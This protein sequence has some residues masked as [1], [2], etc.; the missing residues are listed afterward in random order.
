MR[1]EPH[2]GAQLG[3]YTGPVRERY[4]GN[5]EQCAAY[6]P[7]GRKLLAY[8]KTSFNLSGAVVGGQR[9]VL[10]N[11]VRIEARVDGVNHI[12][13]IDTRALSP[14]KLTEIRLFLE[15]GWIPLENLTDEE[16]WLTFSP[17]YYGTHQWAALSQ[18]F[19]TWLDEIILTLNEDEVVTHQRAGV[20]R[21][22]H[23]P[24]LPHY[25]PESHLESIGF[26]S[27]GYYDKDNIL[28]YSHTRHAAAQILS[29]GYATGKLKLYLQSLLGGIKDKNFILDSKDKIDPWSQQVVTVVKAIM[30]DYWAWVNPGIAF[31]W[32]FSRGLYTADNYRYWLISIIG[33][34]VLAQEI[35][36]GFKF[37][38]FRRTMRKVLEDPD[39]LFSE[40]QKIEAYILSGGVEFGPQIVVAEDLLADLVGVPLHEGWKFN[41]KGTDAQIVTKEVNWEVNPANDILTIRSHTFRRYHI[42]LT[43]NETATVNPFTATISRLEEVEA[44]PE[45]KC[46]RPFRQPMSSGHILEWEDWHE[47]L[48]GQ[49][50]GYL[51]GWI[52]YD[53]PLYCWYCLNDQGV[54]TFVTLRDIVKW[55]DEEISPSEV[56]AAYEAFIGP[57][58][59]AYVC[60]GNQ[61]IRVENKIFSNYVNAKRGY[62]FR[63]EE[64]NEEDAPIHEDLLKSPEDYTYAVQLVDGR[65]DTVVYQVSTSR[66]EASFGGY[67][68][69]GFPYGSINCDGEAAA[70]PPEFAGGL[71]VD[72]ISDWGTWEDYKRTIASG[73]I[74]FGYVL[75]FPYNDGASAYIQ[76]NTRFLDGSVHINYGY[77]PLSFSWNG[78]AVFPDHTVTYDYQGRLW[79]LGSHGPA[80]G[81]PDEM[82]PSYPDLRFAIEYPEG[83]TY[84]SYS[85]NWIETS[86]NRKFYYASA[87]NSDL[88]FNETATLTGEK[89]YYNIPF[90]ISDPN[91]RFLYP[92]AGID[93]E[94]CFGKHAWYVEI[95][96]L[97]FWP[98]FDNVV[99]FNESMGGDAF[100]LQQWGPFEDQVHMPLAPIYNTTDDR[101]PVFESTDGL[102]TSAAK[103]QFNSVFTGWA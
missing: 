90:A 44:T 77:S 88:V 47:W 66:A 20:V 72:I 19:P 15:T 31:S 68:D 71:W 1:D 35:K 80:A 40:R 86:D 78:T 41:Y 5:P 65:L 42:H 61:S 29:P 25:P 51:I 67:E 89:W 53:A 103:R 87:H 27:F 62:Y 18:E 64:G 11:G 102:M 95:N 83:Q 30:G 94:E 85:G 14:G 16:V 52:E 101:Y 92:P 76:R 50:R 59:E 7:I 43:Y 73:N 60:G 36:L 93:L 55:P 84:Y 56:D 48:I 91:A 54:E 63:V 97:D 100:Y 23:A 26:Q 96:Q 82:V 22:P 13:K 32:E 69:L 98:W 79:M 4:V 21:S 38:V 17:L 46:L 74:R 81:M 70:L 2:G 24:T 58:G 6:V 3:R 28:R 99:A 75:V 33:R 34:S 37:A 45:E 10:P 39:T 12:L 57:F 8:L 9:W 49:S